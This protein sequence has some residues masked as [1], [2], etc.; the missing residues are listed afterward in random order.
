MRLSSV[1]PRSV[2]GVNSL[3]SAIA[4]GLFRLLLGNTQLRNGLVPASDL[5]R[6]VFREIVRT[7]IGHGHAAPIDAFPEVRPFAYL[8]DLGRE[9]LDDV[10]RRA[11]WGVDPVPGIDLKP[12][13]PGLG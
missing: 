8:L 6:G 1:S 4:I 7:A 5:R 3:L 11:R 2:I 10:A 13:K 9:P 12:R